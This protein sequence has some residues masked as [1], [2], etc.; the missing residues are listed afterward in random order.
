[1]IQKFKDFSIN[2]EKENWIKDTLKNEGSLRKAFGKK[3][4]EKITIE[5]IDAEISKLKEKDKDKSK[6]GI[7]GLNAND[8]KLYRRL[9]L[10]KNL[11]D[12][13]ESKKYESEIRGKLLSIIDSLVK[14]TNIIDDSELDKLLFKNDNLTF[15]LDELEP[16][17]KFLTEYLPDPN[18]FEEK[19][20]K[21]KSKPIRYRKSK[22]I[23]KRKVRD[24]DD[25]Y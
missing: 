4:G 20:N 23:H 14:L 22:P 18:E 2:E 15:I 10:A 1:M 7:Q 24:M 25:E 6:K 16:N 8:L 19:K 3:E 5:E 11:K 17:L 21:I 13:K 9:I 12:I